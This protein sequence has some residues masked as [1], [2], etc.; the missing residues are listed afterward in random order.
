[1]KEVAGAGALPEPWLPRI[2][3]GHFQDWIDG[4]RSGQQPGSSFCG[5]ATALTEMVLLGNLAL[6]TGKPIL[7]DSE[8]LKARGLPAADAFIKPPLRNEWI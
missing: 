8:N 4:I 2:S 5:D 3:G 6:Q 1:M 7:W